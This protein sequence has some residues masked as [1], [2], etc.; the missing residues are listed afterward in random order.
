MATSDMVR[1]VTEVMIRRGGGGWLN[2]VLW[3]YYRVVALCIDRVQSPQC[4]EYSIHKNYNTI[5]RYYIM[6]YIVM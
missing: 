1:T 3:I 5:Y 4:H 2:L 6:L